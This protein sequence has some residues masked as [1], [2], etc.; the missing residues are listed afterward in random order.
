MLLGGIVLVLAVR[1][2]GVCGSG[3]VVGWGVGGVFG[4]DGT[5]IG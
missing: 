5:G 1:G 2:G 4:P 3:C